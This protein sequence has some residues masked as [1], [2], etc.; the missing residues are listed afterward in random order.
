MA[1]RRAG[2][3]PRRRAL[4]RRPLHPR[5]PRD[6]AGRAR[7]RRRARPATSRLVPGVAG[8]QQVG[9]WGQYA[10]LDG[11][12]YLTISQQLVQ[13]G[14]ATELAAPK[15]DRGERVVSLD[16]DCAGLVGV[17]RSAR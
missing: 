2:L 3:R 6:R 7:S 11:G 17:A 14:W 4:V 13:L 15:T 9:G 5:R 8:L 16:R 12:R 10:A 1:E